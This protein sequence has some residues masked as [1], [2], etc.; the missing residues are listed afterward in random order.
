MSRSYEVII[1]GAGAAG[2]AA[3]AE[4]ARAGRSALVL[5][6]RERVGGRCWTL[7][8]PGLV[9]PVELGAEF[10]HGR[11]AATLSLM[12]QTGTAAVDAPIFRLAMQ[13]G[14][15]RPRGDDLFTQ[16]ERAM[17][18]HARALARKDISFEAFLAHGLRGLSEE[19]RTIA[20]ALARAR[21]S[22]N[23]APRK[24]RK[25]GTSAPRAA[26]AC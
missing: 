25:K 26:T 13:R 19:A 11:P 5:E 14:N 6:A 20:R 21:S 17:R 15:L 4:L 10:V 23:G 22:R 18:R 16:V 24:R 2:L 12:R 8:H 9:A 1:I 3:A 7:R